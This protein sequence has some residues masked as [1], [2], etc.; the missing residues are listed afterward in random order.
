MVAPIAWR[1]LAEAELA[2]A[3]AEWQAVDGPASAD[4]LID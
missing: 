2:A 1:S 4:V 3:A